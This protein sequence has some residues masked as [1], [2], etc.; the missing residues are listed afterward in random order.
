MQ[1]WQGASSGL[2]PAEEL[3]FRER[4]PLFQD[5]IMADAGRKLKQVRER[6]S[7]RYRDVVD[8]S[9][10]IADRQKNPEFALAL[11]R[12]ADIE[13]QGTVPSIHRLYTL[14]AIYR[15]SVSDV[16]KWYGVDPAD[17]AAD[18]TAIELAAT[19]LVGLDVEPDAS[20]VLPNGLEAEFDASRTTFLSRMIQGWG[21]LP[22]AMLKGLDVRKHA[23]GFIGTDDWFMYP[24]LSPG[25]LVLIDDTRKKIA[26]GGWACEHERPIYFLEL[27]DGYACGW[28]HIAG[29]N[30]VL[31][32]H[33]ASRCVAR[34]Y[35]YP[36]E[37]E[38]VGRV[39]GVATR[40]DQGTRR[41]SRSSAAPE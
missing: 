13:N 3:P 25:S 26:S 22:L 1:A 21:R 29:G 11:S 23:Y 17:L 9:L 10:R 12:L 37:I 39:T 35:A 34:V 31:Q 4:Q 5:L 28:A 33:P 14:C 30:V 19:H 6:L 41:R 2:R 38:V 16:L 20:V 36:S 24:I 32:P 18:S 15:L 8:A 40:L 7:L 27:R